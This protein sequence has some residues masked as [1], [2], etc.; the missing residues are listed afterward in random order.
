[1][2]SI[3]QIVLVLLAAFSVGAY[4]ES[5]IAVVDVGAAIFNSEIAKTRIKELESQSSLGTLQAEYEGKMAEVQALQKD[6]DA[7]GLSWSDEQK[8]KY[9]NDLDYLA[10]DV[11]LIKRKVQKEKQVIQQ[12]ILEEVRP[13]AVEQ[14]DALVK[15]EGVEILLRSEAVFW[16]APAPNLT[17][18]LIDRINKAKAAK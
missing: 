12:K 10:A 6:A 7:N 8:V 17:S 3:K 1:M 11:D 5:K 14:L 13:T 16:S 4:A 9:K 18:K 15:E 2:R